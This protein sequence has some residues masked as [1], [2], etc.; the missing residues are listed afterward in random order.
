MASALELRSSMEVHLLLE[1]DKRDEMRLTG[2]ASL[3]KIDVDF[4][5]KCTAPESSDPLAER[6]ERPEAVEAMEAVEQVRWS[7]GEPQRIG[8]DWYE[9]IRT[10]EGLEAGELGQGGRVEL[11]ASFFSRKRGRL[12]A[13]S[14]ERR[15]SGMWAMRCVRAEVHVLPT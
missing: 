8:E 6:V 14:A 4:C 11:W 12:S 10:G 2:S 9:G 5:A 3:S 13:W 7:V 1:R 15:F